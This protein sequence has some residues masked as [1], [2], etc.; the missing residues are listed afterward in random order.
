[1]SN[2][3]SDEPIVSPFERPEERNVW[4][5]IRRGL[6]SKCPRC[7]QGKVYYKY[8]KIRDNCAHCGQELHHHRAD[9]FPPYIAITIVGHIILSAAT[10][11]QI[12][13][14]PPMWLH[15]SLWLPLILIMSLAIL[16]PIKAALVGLQWAHRMHGFN[17]ED[18]SPDWQ[19]PEQTTEI[20]PDAIS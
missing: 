1:M 17:D 8:L 2:L 11:L 18:T 5:A 20:A 16:P 10:T 12:L 9:D 19:E 4:R 14:T 3:N 13:Y 6:T 7:N 15:L